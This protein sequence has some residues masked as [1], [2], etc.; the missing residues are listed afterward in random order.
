MK[1]LYR[2]H[3]LL[4]GVLC[5][6]AAQAQEEGVPQGEPAMQFGQ[7]ERSFV[8]LPDTAQPVSAAYTFVNRGAAP[9]TIRKVEASCGCITVDYPEQPVEPG[10][11]GTIRVTFN[12]KGYSGTIVREIE[13]YT[14]LTEQRPAA[15]LTLTGTVTATDP[16]RSYPYRMGALRTR[17][18][19]VTFGLKQGMTKLAESIVAVNSGKEVLK[20]RADNLPPYLT[21]RTVPAEVEAGKEADLQFLLDVAKLPRTEAKDS[22]SIPV[23][24]EGVNAAREERTV[25]V[26]LRLNGEE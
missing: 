17:Q 13:V 15:C 26:I 19:S 6:L 10:G 22:L 11:K 20:L 2:F 4:L 7:T 18:K 23:L 3:T 25:N 16:W 24:L 5:A 9:L 8:Q 1:R 21:F 14:S 12:P